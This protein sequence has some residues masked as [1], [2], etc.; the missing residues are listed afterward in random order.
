MALTTREW[1]DVTDEEL[2]AEGNTYATLIRT[3][4][5]TGSHQGAPIGAPMH[6]VERVLI[7]GWFENPATRTLSLR[8]RIRIAEVDEVI[9]IEWKLLNAD[10]WDT[11]EAGSFLYDPEGMQAAKEMREQQEQM[12][13]EMEQQMRL[14]G[15]GVALPGGAVP[16][17]RQQRRHPGR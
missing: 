3:E 1:A 15:G 9:L 7:G 11:I 10:E 14:Q 6:T 2:L 8:R 13:R 17:N 5:Q 12:Q 4:Q 16:I